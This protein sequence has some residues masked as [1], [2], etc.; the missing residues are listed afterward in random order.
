MV[1]FNAM[2]IKQKNGLNICFIPKFKCRDV[3]N[4]AYVTKKCNLFYYKEY[5]VNIL[6]IFLLK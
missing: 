6:N 5:L 1:C 3:C 2:Q 4:V